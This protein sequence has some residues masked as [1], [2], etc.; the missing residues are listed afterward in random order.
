MILSDV[1]LGEFVLEEESHLEV[2]QSMVGLI[3][4]AKFYSDPELVKFHAT[5]NFN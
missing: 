2:F 4:H 5:I 1:Y 3:Y